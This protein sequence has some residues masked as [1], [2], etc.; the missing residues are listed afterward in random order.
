MKRINP[1]S[2]LT[3]LLPFQDVTRTKAVAHSCG[4]LDL[5]RL[6]T[7]SPVLWPQRFSISGSWFSH[8]PKLAKPSAT[9]ISEDQDP[10]NASQEE[11]FQ[12]A[13]EA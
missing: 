5:P 3:T 9:K 8:P 7:E 12:N 6:L 10:D 1:S 4:P 13:S 2:R 11:A